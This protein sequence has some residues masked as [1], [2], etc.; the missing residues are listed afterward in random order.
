MII[1]KLRKKKEEERGCIN[2]KY[3]KPHLGIG[4]LQEEEEEIEEC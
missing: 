3:R 4:G 1:T 2:D